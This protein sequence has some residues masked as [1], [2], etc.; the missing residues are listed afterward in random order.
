LDDRLCEDEPQELIT[1]LQRLC[2]SRTH[3]IA[4]DMQIA[5]ENCGSQ[6]VD[7]K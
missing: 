5:D 7:P 4:G 2:G 1:D 6:T 3:S